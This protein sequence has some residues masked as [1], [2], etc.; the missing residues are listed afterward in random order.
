MFYWQEINST[1]C[2]IINQQSANIMVLIKK[3]A[4][5]VFEVIW[6]EKEKEKEKEIQIW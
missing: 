4:A 3:D 1:F 2:C 6:I 5:G